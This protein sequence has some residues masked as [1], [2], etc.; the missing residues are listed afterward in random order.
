[1]QS[2][3][4]VS[5]LWE[6]DDAS[7]Q[8][9]S[10]LLEE[11]NLN[12][13][14]YI[15]PIDEEFIWKHRNKSNT[16][17]FYKKLDDFK[18]WFEFYPLIQKISISIELSKMFLLHD[19]KIHNPFNSAYLY[20]IDPGITIENEFTNLQYI[21]NNKFITADSKLFGGLNN[22]ITDINNL[23]Y[24]FLK[25]TLNEKLIE[26]ANH[27]FNII[28]QK[29]PDLVYT[30]HLD[31]LI[32]YKLKNCDLCKIPLPDKP[33]HCIKTHLYV[34]T[35]NSPAQFEHLLKSFEKADANFL[36]KPSKFLLN[37][38]TD[39]TTDQ[40]YDDLCL[41]YD[42]EQIK[43]DNIG[44]CRGRQFVAEHFDASDAD[45]YIFFEDDMLLHTHESS[46]QIHTNISSSQGGYCTNG[47]RKYVT[48]LYNK[49]LK[50]MHKEKYDYLK[51][52]FTEVYGGN[53]IQWA[54]YNVPDEVRHKYFP[55]KKTKP[56][57]GLDPK[58]PLTQF[59]CIKRSDDITYIEGDIYYCNWPLWFNREGNRK[60]FL[61][62]KFAYPFEQTWMSLVF[63]KQKENLF[64]VAVL[65]LSPIDHDRIHYYAGEERREN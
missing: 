13:C 9:F 49:T 41:K 40:M 64:K 54:W 14:I 50:I 7:K 48:D 30:E 22:L 5:G 34:L 24:G 15:D 6:P 21:G 56:T 3:T 53:E 18:T 57:S 43:K 1:M 20:W 52:N 11:C 61:E 12:M 62:P 32:E 25:Q 42:F 37:N 38:S 39:R 44:I 26:S 63:Q 35:Y 10:K 60:V 51:L 27:I 23:Y 2:I 46:L 16:K 17:I 4:I 59:G 19:I 29:F 36:K 55:N 8:M 33:F 28:A 31:T 45:Y 65:L 47:F 58:P